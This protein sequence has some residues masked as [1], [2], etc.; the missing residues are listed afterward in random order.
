MQSIFEGLRVVDLTEGM[1]S[2][3]SAVL[4]DFGADVVKIETES[5]DSERGRP[6]F[7]FWNRGKRSLIANL[8]SASGQRRITELV[9][10][11]DVFIESLSSRSEQLGL[12]PDSTR[13]RNPRLV[14]CSLTGFGEATTLESFGHKDEIVMAKVGRLMA[15]D[16]LSGAHED[17]DH[18]IYLAAP[19]S[20]Y[21]C[22]TLALQ[23]IVSSLLQRERT[24][25]G[26]AV[27]TSLLDGVSA[28]TMR[29][30]F[31]RRGDDV[32][33]V[34][35]RGD[36]TIPI[37]MRGIRLCFLAVE[38]SD[39]RYI[40]MCC[41]QPHLY[42]NWMSCIGLGDELETD[43]WSGLPL[44][45]KS[46]ADADEWEQRVR[47][48][49]RT[50]S[51]A[52]WMDIFRN[53]D[54]GADPFLTEDE[55]LRHPQLVENDRLITIDD[56]ELGPILQLGPLVKATATPAHVSGPAPSL[57]S[58]RDWTGWEPRS[59]SLQSAE[60]TTRL[61]LDGY[62]IL[63][64]ASFLAAPLGPTLL[65]ELGARV[66]KVE[67]I[68]GDPFRSSGLEFVHI[69]NGKESIALDLKTDQGRAILHQLI[70]QSD[71]LIHNFR[72]GVPEKLG[73]GYDEACK[74][75]PDLVYLY[76]ASYG[77]NGPESHRAAFHSTP[78]AL[79]G[80]GIL[81]AGKSNPPVNDSYADP[82]SGLATGV[83]LA[84]GLLARERYGVGQYLET[85]MLV[86]AG[87]VHSARMESYI[88][89][90]PRPQLTQDQ[91]G[92]SAF[93]RLYECAEGWIM[94]SVDDAD[95]PSLI[96]LVGAD[97][98]SEDRRFKDPS[99]RLEN[100]RM[101]QWL[102]EDR[103]KTN[104]AAT[105]ESLG[106]QHD[107]AI[108]SAAERTLEEFLV[109]SGLLESAEHPAFGSY[110]RLQPRVRVTG[111]ERAHGL[112]CEVGEHTDSILYSLGYE[113]AQV[114]ALEAAKVVKRAATERRHPL[115][116]GIAHLQ[117]DG[118]R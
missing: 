11:A 110:W 13:A 75:R 117:M 58:A 113:P 1:L 46:H 104:T 56:P 36:G 24:G 65:A 98:W 14:H 57:N 43:R 93:R 48:R 99:T 112:P 12:D 116:T 41:R 118:T 55:F 15:N 63:E 59:E 50:K 51:Q 3:T 94:L 79:C 102:L 77:S 33:P 25:L 40:Q 22:A 38:T 67:P 101:L 32:I 111:S 27:S 31:E 10:D 5:G 16:P 28:A 84:L 34:R 49:M 8:D 26:R 21:G 23:G 80:G 81:Q 76:G 7:N 92:Y 106:Q 86:S 95:W 68:D 87:W 42:R 97:E 17:I 83:A 89:Q 100:D 29:L 66:I 82:C 47:E 91:L 64:V 54:I 107:L 62:T 90:P 9:D 69:A 70:E 114:D 85:S 109:H 60:P 71:A 74:I 53:L 19:T 2:M 37:L 35:S 4:A 18:P 72:P 52:E 105:W 39:N 73:F 20:T 61:P 103:F 45:V 30:A 115:G 78:N 108:A 6:G 44:A 88:G 96:A